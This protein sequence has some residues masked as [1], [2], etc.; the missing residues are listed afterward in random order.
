MIEDTKSFAP[1]EIGSLKV[2]DIPKHPKGKF[3]LMI[4]FVFY[5]LILIYALYFRF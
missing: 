4:E 3:K 1:S 5:F 2:R